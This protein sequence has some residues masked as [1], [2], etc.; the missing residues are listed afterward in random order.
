MILPRNNEKEVWLNMRQAIS[1][2]SFLRGV[3]AAGALYTLSRPMAGWTE[4]TPSSSE[5]GFPLIDFHAHVEGRM[6]TARLLE[7]AK[8]RGV[9]IGIAQH[10]GCTEEM[11]DDAGIR[12]YI[13]TW[14]GLPVYKGMQ[15][16]G[17][18][19]MR[20]FSNDVVAQLDFVLADAMTFPEK[21]GRWVRLWTPEAQITD[22]QDFMERYVEFN[23]QVISREP[24]D[25]FANPTFLPDAI[26]KEYDALWTKE[27][28]R[29]VIDAAVKY[30][31]VI[32]INSRYK[33]P[34]LAFLRMAKDAGAKFSF[35]SN[36]HDESVAI[37]DY[38][39]KTAKELGL[40][41]S[42]M[43][44]PAPADRKPILTRALGLGEG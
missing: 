11:K 43:F 4:E 10:G 16:E 44:A 2:R 12:Q 23:V 31:V 13:A 5:L 33:I 25:I 37:L 7:L 39:V 42:D 9:K 34:S 15:A 36:A 27:R 14:E 35:G 29:K 20:C 21:D 28:M 18:T 40:T 17:H 19:W 26:A 3:S 22:R 8:E 30:G 1:R 41:R 32:E 38:S 6:T 24:I